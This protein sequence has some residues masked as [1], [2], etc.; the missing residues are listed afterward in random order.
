MRR[1]TSLFL[2]VGLFCSG[3][4]GFSFAQT[5]NENTVRIVFVSRSDLNNN[6]GKI[7]PTITRGMQDDAQN[8]LNS[9]S[10]LKSYLQSRKVELSNV[11]KIDTARNGDKI[12]YVK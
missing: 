5:M 6:S 2:A 4:A 9:N 1:A 10:G 3:A 8:E 12:V 11:V 7:L